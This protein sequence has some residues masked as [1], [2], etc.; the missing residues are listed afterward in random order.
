MRIADLVDHVKYAH[1]LFPPNDLDRVL[2][3]KLTDRAQA[4]SRYLENNDDRFLGSIIIAAYDGHPQFVPISLPETALLGELRPQLGILRFDGKE[5]YYALDGQHR[6]AGLRE[7]YIINPDRYVGDEIGVT[8]V[9]HSKDEEGVKR[10][11]RL[12]ATLNRYAKKTTKAEDLMMDEDNP[13]DIFARR[14]VREEG[15][16]RYRVRVFKNT[17]TGID[18][19]SGESIPPSDKKHLMN[20]LTL[21]R[22]IDGLLPQAFKDRLVPQTLPDLDDLDH[23]YDEVLRRWNILIKNVDVWNRAADESMELSAFRGRHGGNVLCRPIAIV[24]FAEACGE[25]FDKE[26][27]EDKISSITKDYADITKHPWDGLLWN[28]NE[29]IMYDGQQKRKA[30]LD[31]WRYV[32][33]VEFDKAKVERQWIAASD[34]GIIANQPTLI[35]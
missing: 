19:V 5:M 16:F 25:Y 4:I 21:K 24:A 15:F 34:S 22:C 8:I 27:P 9:C 13:A 14:M 3:R 31:L 12:F 7:A 28:S 10:A 17:K 1:E 11:R 33:G 35:I 6:L 26:M 18:I 29:N 2:Q 32:L 20:I 30:T 23:A